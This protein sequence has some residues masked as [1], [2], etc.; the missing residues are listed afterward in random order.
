[1]LFLRCSKSPLPGPIKTSYMRTL[2]LSP[3]TGSCLIVII[4]SAPLPP[5]CLHKCAIVG[6]PTETLFT[7]NAW[8]G[9]VQKLLQV[10]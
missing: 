6:V 4:G 9:K 10:D 3:A 5:S 7:S 8:A 2:I 1:M